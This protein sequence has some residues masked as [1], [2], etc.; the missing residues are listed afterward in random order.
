MQT[1]EDISKITSQKGYLICNWDEVEESA[2]FD[3]NTSDGLE[4]LL[5]LL[6]TLELNTLP[7]IVK[8]SSGY[9][10]ASLTGSL[11]DQPI[12]FGK[13]SVNLSKES[14]SVKKGLLTA[15]VAALMAKVDGVIEQDEI[16]ALQ[17]I[18]YSLPY[19]TDSEKYSIFLRGLVF[20]NQ[21]SPL[22]TIIEKFDTLDNKAKEFVIKIV[23]DIAVADGRI[24]KAERL[25]L[26]SLYRVSGLP[27]NRVAK[28]LKAHA[29]QSGVDLHR[30]KVTDLYQ[31]PHVEVMCE[32]SESILEDLFSDFEDL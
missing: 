5:E 25:F 15:K 30:S 3:T 19:L 16:D 21:N 24:E 7:K 6:H 4:L 11:M 2:K 10:I 13:C 17:R 18:I 22:D 8:T 28:D 1:L 29:L 14:N 12:V 31:E 32:E 20:L 9:S 27:T 23:K 26:A